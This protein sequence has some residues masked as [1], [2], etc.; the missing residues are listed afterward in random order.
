[1]KSLGTAAIDKVRNIAEAA[2]ADAEK[3]VPGAVVVVV[4]KDGEEIFSHAA[5]KRGCESSEPMTLE[6]IF[7]IASCTKMI[8]GVACMQLVE[9]GKLRLD[10]GNQV[11]DLC[12]EL[13]AV[14]VLLDDGTLIEKKRSITL[15]MLLSHTGELQ[16]FI[17]YQ[18]TNLLMN[19]ITNS[20]LRVY[21][22]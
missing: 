22:F 18:V 12:P 16:M 6:N 2:C 14:K 9:Q 8:I 10:D 15:R 11:E 13:K 5:G 17:V 20:G 19:M 3:G 7:W 1:M 4:G 21:L